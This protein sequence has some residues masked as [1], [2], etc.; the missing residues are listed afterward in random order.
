MFGIFRRKLKQ[1]T[2]QM[3]FNVTKGDTFNLS[4]SGDMN[5]RRL[6]KLRIELFWVANKVGATDFDLDGV[7]MICAPA[8]PGDQPK[9]VA[10]A[11]EHACYFNNKVAGGGALISL[12]DNRKGGQADDTIPEET[13]KVDLEA[14][15]NNAAV[16]SVDIWVT[17]HE[18]AKN[19]L[20]FGMVPSARVVIFDDETNT[21][22][23]RHELTTVSPTSASVHFVTLNKKGGD[24]EVIGVDEGY[25]EELGAVLNSYV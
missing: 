19:R 6:K 14:L 11:G 15:G 20:N 23:A 10:P 9:F 5:G 1:D 24:W 21:E 7:G 12:G 22:L 16:G 13:M 25:T 4:K 17:I 8:N 3:T 2:K 18:A